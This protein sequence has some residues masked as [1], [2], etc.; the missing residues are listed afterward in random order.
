MMNPSTATEVDDDPTVLRCQRRVRKWAE[1]GAN[2]PIFG[3]FGGVEVCNVFGWRET[4]SRKL[5]GLIASGIDIIG[6]DNDAA[7]AQAA[8]EALM[9]VCGWGNPGNLMARGSQVLYMLRKAGI[10][11]YALKIN[12]DGTPQHPLYIGY[13]AVPVEIE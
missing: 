6:P 1:I 7:I 4:D 2:V 10:Q 5:P 9:V 13:D 3:E 11:P 8:S 12:Q